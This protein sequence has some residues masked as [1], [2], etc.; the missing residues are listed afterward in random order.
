MNGTTN[1]PENENDTGSQAT[2]YVRL[3]DE[4]MRELLM[5]QK[6]IG[7]TNQTCG[8]EGHY[9]DENNP[10]RTVYM[11]VGSIF[12]SIHLL[13]PKGELGAGRITDG[14][15]IL[16]PHESPYRPWADIKR[17]FLSCCLLIF[18][19]GLL[20]CAIASPWI[21]INLLANLFNSN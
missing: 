14:T 3:L 21:I 17:I 8:Y 19:I 12:P 16:H 20:S 5:K 15:W 7:V 9:Y 6:I 13:P 2:L 18:A 10:S 4:L 11:T 1:G